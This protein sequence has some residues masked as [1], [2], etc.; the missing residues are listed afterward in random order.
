[1][2][3][4]Q[5][6]SPDQPARDGRAVFFLGTVFLALGLFVLLHGIGNAAAN[7]SICAQTFAHDSTLISKALVSMYWANV[8]AGLAYIILFVAWW[9]RR[10]HPWS[11]TNDVA[12]SRVAWAGQRAW[13]LAIQELIDS[14]AA[15]EGTLRQRLEW[16][17]HVVLAISCIASTVVLLVLLLTCEACPSS[18]DNECTASA[19]GTAAS[20]FILIIYFDLRIKFRRSKL[21]AQ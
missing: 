3:T 16:L 5:R 17:V 10:R 9:M 11:E 2:I 1:M 21:K 7:V 8:A 18:W 15:P 20:G 12:F 14:P 6:D 19:A 4:P 13:E